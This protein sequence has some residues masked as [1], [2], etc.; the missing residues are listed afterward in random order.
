MS[1]L[2][3]I[4]TIRSKDGTSLAYRRS[5]TGPPLILV[6][7][8]AGSYIRW[9]PILPALESHFSVYALNRRG[10]G[11]SGDA[12]NYAIEREFEDVGA[13]VEAIEAPVYLLGHSYGAICALEAALLTP[14][15]RKLVLYEPP[16]L[17]PGVTIYREGLIDYL[18]KLLVAGNREELLLTFIREVV[19]MPASEQAQFRAS[20]A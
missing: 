3:T 2:Q 19:R 16:I 1:I 5:G 20:P 15:I 14:N 7:G 12:E 17:G 8:T 18:E 6:H 10:R 4:E 13:L 11:E 9:A